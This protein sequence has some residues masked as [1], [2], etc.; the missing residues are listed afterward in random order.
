MALLEGVEQT[1]AYLERHPTLL[2]LLRYRTKQ[3]IVVLVVIFV[4]LSAWTVG[5]FSEP[6][7][8]W[9]GVAGF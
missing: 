1:E 7:L 4:V 3:T 8:R 6:I 2:Y 5:G 9:L